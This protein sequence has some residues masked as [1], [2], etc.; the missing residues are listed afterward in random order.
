MLAR[1]PRRSAQGMLFD[2]SLATEPIVGG[3][4]LVDFKPRANRVCASLLVEQLVL[5]VVLVVDTTAISGGQSFVLTAPPRMVAAQS[6]AWT[7]PLR[8][9]MAQWPAFTGPPKTTTAQSFAWTSPPSSLSRGR[10]RH[11]VAPPSH[12]HDVGVCVLCSNGRSCNR[13]STHRRRHGTHSQLLQPLL[14][15]SH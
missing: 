11:R 12:A 13:R 8:T 10:L 6:L 5:Q 15:S 14:A 7:G 2:D 9:V 1:T 3:A 4:T